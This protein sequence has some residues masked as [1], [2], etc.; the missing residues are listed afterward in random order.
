[1][2][3]VHCA[4]Y[5]VSR[6]RGLCWRCY[7]KSAVRDRYPPNRQCAG[8]GPPDR[9][10]PACPPPQPTS[11]RP[12]TPEKVA[13]LKE[14]ARRRFDQAGIVLADYVALI[15]LDTRNGR[16][17]AQSFLRIEFDLRHLLRI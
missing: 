14:R 5:P 3:C 7:Y 1:M 2:L 15:D 12:G 11:A 13:V 10:G 6:P 8:A 16:A 4:R 9:H 17:K